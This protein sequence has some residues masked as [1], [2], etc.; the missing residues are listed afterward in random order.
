MVREVVQ[1]IWCKSSPVENVKVFVE[2]A[3][4]PELNIPTTEDVNSLNK[5][6]K[7]Q[8]MFIYPPR[9]PIAFVSTRHS[10]TIFCFS[11]SS[12]ADCASLTNFVLTSSYVH[13]IVVI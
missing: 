10:A 12:L 11:L 3:K 4:E 9:F 8:N 7:V 2:N 13:T 1:L 6:G 5:L